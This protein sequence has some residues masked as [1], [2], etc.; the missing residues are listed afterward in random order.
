MTDAVGDG[1]RLPKLDRRNFG[2]PSCS[3]FAQHEW[4]EV[5]R[6]NGHALPGWK[7]STCSACG[8]HALW[9]EDGLIFP[10]MKVGPAPAPDLPEPVQNVYLE[11]QQVALASPR[12]AAALLR[13]ALQILV[14]QVEPGRD[15]LNVK[16]GKLSANGT[17]EKLVQAM[18]AL[19]VIGNNAVHPGQISV[20]DLQTVLS[21]FDLLNLLGELLIGEPAR[22]RRLYDALP[23]SAKEAIRK[24]DAN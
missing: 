20:D 24:R 11:A 21:L 15:S 7:S 5:M 13:L 6:E 23:A 19:R 10:P 1:D 16:I 22:V 2:C 12:S 14:D 18:D 8:S 4:R 3:A 17:P 9:F